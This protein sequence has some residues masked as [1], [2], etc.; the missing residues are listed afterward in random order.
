MAASLRPRQLAKVESPAAGSFSD[1][2]LPELLPVELRPLARRCLPCLVRIAE[3]GA[4]RALSRVTAKSSENATIY[5]I[6]VKNTAA[7]LQV[8]C[9]TVR[10]LVAA[11]ELEAVRIRPRSVRIVKAS[12]DA[13]I[14]RKRQ[15]NVR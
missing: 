4:S 2:D 8:S 5:H 6:T 10:N 13:F 3:I 14:E 15:K 9:G 7:C 1:S 11:G 12:L